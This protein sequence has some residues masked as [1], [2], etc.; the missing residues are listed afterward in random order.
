MT[1]MI[2]RPVFTAAAIAALAI[3]ITATSADA[4]RRGYVVAES[5]FGY[6]RVSGAVRHTRLGRQVQ[7]PGGN[8]VYCAR[9]CAETLRVKTVDFWHSD[10]GAGPLNST[11]HDGGI[12][13]KLRIW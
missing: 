12:F 6:G 8:W 4:G 9:S 3:T 13:G 11:T 1:T 2:N 10:E 5:E 7:L